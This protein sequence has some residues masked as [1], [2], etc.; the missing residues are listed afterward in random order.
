MKSPVNCGDLLR[1]FK[2]SRGCGFFRRQFCADQRFHLVPDAGI[3]FDLDV[4]PHE[5]AGVPGILVAG[6]VCLVVIELIVA[7][8]LRSG[9][10]GGADS[11]AAVKQSVALIEVDGLG[12]VGRDARVSLPDLRDAVDENGQQHR[13]LIVLKLMG[14]GDRL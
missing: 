3:V 6:D 8:D 14:H 12:H 4:R 7:E 11:G 1:L 2:Q 10:I 5:E 9:W 13:N